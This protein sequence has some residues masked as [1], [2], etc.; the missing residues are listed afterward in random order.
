MKV[1]I[2]YCS[3]TGRTHIAA[4]LVSE[5][6]KKCGDFEI[7]LMNLENEATVDMD[8]LKASQMVVFGSPTYSA[9]FAWPLKRWYDEVAR[10]C[11]LHGKLAGNFATGNV[12]GGGQDVAISSMAAH[13]LV[14]GMLVYSGGG[15]LTH[16]GAVIV[17]I[18]DEAQRERMITFG[19]RMGNKMKD[20]FSVCGEIM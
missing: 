10:D 6:I 7:R 13:E 8:F 1:T 20:L 15:P 11:N 2:L 9:S 18:D 12:I 3:R 16:L 17:D 5:G 4:E 19:T 14:R